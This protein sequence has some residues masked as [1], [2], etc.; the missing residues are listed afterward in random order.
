MC[1]NTYET[2]LLKLIKKTSMVDI[3]QESWNSKQLKDSEERLLVEKI[4]IY[5]VLVLSSWDGSLYECIVQ[6]HRAH[7]TLKKQTKNNFF[8]SKQNSYI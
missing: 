3:A 2:V 1:H 8:C 4:E 6:V 5:D 7:E